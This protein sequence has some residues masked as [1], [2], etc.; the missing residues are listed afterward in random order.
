MQQQRYQLPK[1]WQRLD[2]LVASLA[3]NML[4]LAL[5]IVTLQIYDRII[6]NAA[7][8]TLSFLVLGLFVIA[9]AEAFLRI[10]RSAIMGWIGARFVH[11]L[12]IGALD[13]ILDADILAFNKQAV[14]GYL[15]RFHG[16]EA[17]REFYSGQSALVV[18]DLPFVAV[19]L[20]LIAMI[21][22]W[23]VLIPICLLV[24]AVGLAWAMGRW[25]RGA[26]FARTQT[27][28]QRNNFIIEALSG[29]HTIK[30]MALETQMLRRYE[31]L[32]GRSAERVAHLSTITS[33]NQAV[34]SGLSQ[35][36]M[37]AV[38]SIG[39][40]SVID[41]SMTMGALAATTMLTGRAIQP[42]T[43]A[44]SIWTQYQRT[45]MSH[46][47]LSGILDLPADVPVGAQPV[48]GLRGAIAFENVGFSYPGETTPL[49]SHV[50]LTIEP[51]QTIGIIGKNGV[52]KSTLL[53]MM[54]GILRP[55][56]GR[57]LF[58][59]RDIAGIDPRSLG[60]HIGF[61]PQQAALFSGTLLENLTM[62]QRGPE[63]E[64]AI[65]IVEKLGL[66]DFVTSLPRGLD[67]R[68]AESVVESLPDGVKQRIGIVR[69]LIGTPPVLLFDDANAGLDYG[70]DASLRSLLSEI[71]GRQTLVLVSFRPSLQR[72]CDTVWELSPSGLSPVDLPAIP[73][74]KTV[75]PEPAA[76]ADAAAP[77]MTIA[78]AALP[79]AADQAKVSAA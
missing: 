70:A 11:R 27:D 5:P 41:G 60:E 2:V 6:P 23:M 75:D 71:R 42:V 64:E 26:I 43:R 30:S 69:A 38:V 34:G 45:R 39:C 31:R 52:G 63:V 25:L 67:T 16:I 33:I 55:T 66:S 59:G 44:I 50:N 53:M 20:G 18:V 36:S 4:A 79:P 8:E 3:V 37:V 12:G 48:A 15:D 77:Q 46:E 24:V 68:L 73:P 61:M 22:G 62:F 14:G 28:D 72:L 9:L 78:P 29:I 49:F 74:A 58:D 32:Q 13:A 21:S 1:I 47:R 35:V 19:Y 40:F 51:G 65:G 17:L 10:G 57:I 56:Q 76:N 7:Y 54:A